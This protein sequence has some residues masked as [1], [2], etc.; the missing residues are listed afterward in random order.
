MAKTRYFVLGKEASI[1]WD[2]TLKL[3]VVSRDQTNPTRAE[4]SKF[5]KRLDQALK[6]GHVIELK[7]PVPV[8]STVQVEE[9]KNRVSK[10][11][12]ITEMT[13]KELINHYKDNYQVSPKDLKAFKAMALEEKVKFLQEE[14]ET[15]S[16]GGEES[17]D[18][19]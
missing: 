6:N 1:F 19:E 7:A 15:E 17:E 10:P 3:K 2:P 11:K 9:E 13:D 12:S 4:I 5:S 8:P 16:D 14:D 18:D